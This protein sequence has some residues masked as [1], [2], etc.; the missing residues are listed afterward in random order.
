MRNVE[1]ADIEKMVS[2]IWPDGG[3]QI[4]LAGQHVRFDHRAGFY[5]DVMVTSA[6][7][8]RSADGFKASIVVPAIEAL[9]KKAG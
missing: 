5:V 1:F 2:S 7:L 6:D 9:R 3:V 4:S 8:E